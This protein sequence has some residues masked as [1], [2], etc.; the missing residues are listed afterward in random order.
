MNNTIETVTYI[1]DRLKVIVMNKPGFITKSALL[2]FPIGG[3]NQ[4][5]LKEGKKVPFE[6]GAAHFL[7]HKLFEDEGVELTDKFSKLGASANAFTSHTQTVYYYKTIDQFEENLKVLMNLAFYPNFTEEGI[8]KERGII[9]QE[10]ASSHDKPFYKQ[11]TK[12]MEVLYK[13]H[14]F[15]HDIIG[16]ET[17]VSNISFET[18]KTIHNTFYQPEYATL[19]LGGDDAFT[20]ALKMLEA[21]PFKEATAFKK[22]PVENV[23][24]KKAPPKVQEMTGDVHATYVLT[25]FRLDLTFE[26][27]KEEYTFFIALEMALE[28]LFGSSSDWVEEKLKQDIITESFFHDVH[29]D[30][31]VAFVMMM[32]Q[33]RKPEAFL[34]EMDKMTQAFDESL[35]R[36]IDFERIK[37]AAIGDYILGNDSLNHLVVNRAYTVDDDITR[38][39]IFNIQKGMHFEDVILAFKTFQN[40]SITSSVVLKP[41]TLE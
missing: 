22:A 33:T 11:Y 34:K 26:T 8:E 27:I 6:P 25:G 21:F 30:P 31:S 24:L 19:I 17:S 29:L 12:L 15:A 7:E 37:K 23:L 13:N 2:S 14:P 28:M 9:L 36:E 40:Q 1:Q 38:D 35:F 39:D 5:Y 18:L 4:S 10:M 20:E 32:S 3:L 41:K 16:D